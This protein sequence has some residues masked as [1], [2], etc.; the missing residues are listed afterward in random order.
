ME[1]LYSAAVNAIS[2]WARR[3]VDAPLG[4]RPSQ[5]AMLAGS[6]FV[7]TGAEAEAC[8]LQSQLAAC[9]LLDAPLLASVRAEKGWLLFDLDKAA[10]DAY[11]CSLPDDF[12]HGSA[13][14]DRRME[15][16]LRHGDRPLPDCPA[17][18]RAVLTASIASDRGRW[19]QADERTVLTMTHKLSGMERVAAEQS[20]ARA[21]KII[22][23]E[24][25]T[26][27]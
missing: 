1:T 19:T 22:L 2:D 9:R 4:L 7:R 21:A 25:R 10:F 24:R 17:V 13:Y 12:A 11:A 8:A 18:L 20:A 15:I 26:L 14:L 23:F 3:I 5:K 16:L 27:L 6:G